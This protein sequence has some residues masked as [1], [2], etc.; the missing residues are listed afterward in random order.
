MKFEAGK[1]YNTR[2]GEEA[3]IYCVD[4]PGACPIHGRI[5]ATLYGWTEGGRILSVC[6]HPG[7]LIA[8]EP[9]RISRKV[10]VNF[11]ETDLHY[12]HFSKSEAER[13]E[14]EKCVRLAIPCLLT[15]IV[16]SE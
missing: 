12:I 4:A 3:F 15:E 16:T 14:N 5:G 13:S 6:S 2:G 1:T 10:W 7:D 8:H 11:Y 9:E